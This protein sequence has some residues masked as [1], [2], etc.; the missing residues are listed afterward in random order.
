MSHTSY[1][2]DTEILYL[3]AAGFT[4]RQ[5]TQFSLKFYNLFRVNPW[6]ASELE[7]RQREEQ[8]RSRSTYFGHNP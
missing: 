3:K 8:L 4:D 6:P 5:I 1:L 7:R 2:S